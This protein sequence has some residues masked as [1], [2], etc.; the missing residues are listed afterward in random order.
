MLAALGMPGLRSQHLV[1]SPK[2]VIAAV[3]LTSLH[4]SE[5]LRC[6]GATWGSPRSRYEGEETAVAVPRGRA[7]RLRAHRR[8]V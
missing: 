6:P 7:A 1:P 2:A 8:S 4:V 5:E 3:R